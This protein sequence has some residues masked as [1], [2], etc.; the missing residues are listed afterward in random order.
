MGQRFC[1]LNREEKEAEGVQCQKVGK[2]SK[3]PLE[4][5]MDTLITKEEG[6]FRIRL[7]LSQGCQRILATMGPYR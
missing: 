5:H 1:I 2:K 6:T 4:Y 7:E 3:L